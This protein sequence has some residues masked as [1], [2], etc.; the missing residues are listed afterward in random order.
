MK[1]LRYFRES[2]DSELSKEIDEFFSDIE[3]TDEDIQYYFSTALDLSEWKYD[4]EYFL[5]EDY[6]PCS[7]S[8]L[9]YL[10]KKYNIPGG[11]LSDVKSD[12]DKLRSDLR[13]DGCKVRIIFGLN[14]HIKEYNKGEKISSSTNSEDYVEYGKIVQSFQSPLHQFQ[15]L[16]ENIS[17]VETNYC[18]NIIDLTFRKKIN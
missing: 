5:N 8:K 6:P 2:L 4:L 12:L 18:L 9:V 14:N 17:E 10:Y 1:H 16:E 15:Q 3:Y 7:F 13:S 11:S